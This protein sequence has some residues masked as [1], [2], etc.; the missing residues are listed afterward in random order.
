MSEKERKMSNIINFDEILAKEICKIAGT[1]N[2][3][4]VC[5]TL[6]THTPEEKDETKNKSVILQERI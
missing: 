6:I 4:D 1:D 3:D 5:I 2:L